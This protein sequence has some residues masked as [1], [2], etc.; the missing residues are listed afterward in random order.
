MSSKITLTRDT[1]RLSINQKIF[2]E[3]NGYLVIPRLIALDILKECSQR[4][5]DIASGKHPRGEIIVMKDVSDRGVVNKI[6]DLNYDEVF[7]KYI[8]CKELL[9][10]V[11]S[12]TGGN[13]MA[14]H[15]MLIAKPPDVG[16][17][18]SRHPPHQDLYYF[19]F[20]PI[21][22]IVAAWT[23]IEPCDVLNGCLYVSPGSHKTN[24]LL[25][26][27][28]PA[29]TKAGSA[30]KFYYGI[31]DLPV[32][33]MPWINAEML[34]GDTIFLHPL[35]VHGSGV[36]TSTRTRKAISCHY[37]AAESS[38][39]EVKGTVQEPVDVEVM[40][41]VRR[42]FPEITSINYSDVWRYKSTLVRGIRS[43]L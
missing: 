25:P 31:Q 10:I 19:P 35:L 37:A 23:A 11:E 30:N 8:E 29:D 2:Y 27:F 43:L 40:E 13:I 16:S 33:T 6:Q 39:I 34:P 42:R 28:Y 24:P 5:D 20:R 36:N 32:S 3:D 22:K 21:N 17:G 12:F 26:H 7:Q 38:Y 41:V 14:M 9:D 15:S 4:F 18:S 1:G